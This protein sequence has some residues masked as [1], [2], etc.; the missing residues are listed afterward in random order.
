MHALR[1][2][3]G[4]SA[5]FNSKGEIDLT[6]EDIKLGKKLDLMEKIH[7]KPAGLI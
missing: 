1:G 5:L 2:I 4:I 7:K 6:V 3:P